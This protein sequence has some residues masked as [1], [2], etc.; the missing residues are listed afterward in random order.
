MGKFSS[1]RV[2][3]VL[4]PR[5]RVGSVQV[6][7]RMGRVGGRKLRVEGKLGEVVRNL[8]G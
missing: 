6:E 3:R 8:P 4:G 7:L 5:L 1:G 2:R